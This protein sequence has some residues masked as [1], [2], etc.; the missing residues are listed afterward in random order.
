MIL[1]S[2]TPDTS[3]T[4]QSELPALAQLVNMGYD[5]ITREKARQLRGGNYQNVLLERILKERLQALNRIPS[6]SGG[7]PFSE[8]NIDKAITR[9]RV[10][11]GGSLAQANKAVY[12]K[13]IQGIALEQEVE[14]STQSHSLR[15]IDWQNPDNNRFHVVTQYQVRNSRTNKSQIPDLALFVNGI[16]LA[17]IECKAPH[18]EV[19]DAIAQLRAYQKEE[20]GIPALFHYAQLL[21]AVNRNKARYA[22]VTTPPKFWTHWE[23]PERSKDKEE[24]R[25]RSS[26]TTSKLDDKQRQAIQADYPQEWEELKKEDPST[27]SEQAKLLHSLC[28][29]ERLLEIIRHF[30][31]FDH[32]DKKIARAHQFAVVQSAMRRLRG[33]DDEKKGKLGLIW[34]A[35]GA[36]KSLT[37]VWLT[38]NLLLRR[39]VNNP[40]V[41]LATDRIDLERQLHG[42]FRACQ[43]EPEQA[44]TGKKLAELI[45]AG[46]ARVITTV[47]HK[48]ERV[49][50]QRNLISAEDNIF[51]LVD[52]SH[53]TQYGQ[54]AASMR[55]LLPK[56]HYIGF[57]GTPLLKKEKNTFVTFGESIEPSYPMDKAIKDKVVLPLQYERRQPSIW[58]NREFMDRRF[59]K[60]TKNLNREAQE[61]LKGEYASLSKLIQTDEVI[62]AHA[63]DI[64]RHYREFIKRHGRG[65]KAQLAAPRKKSAIKYLWEL[66]SCEIEAD[67]VISAPN[68]YEGEE[69]EQKQPAPDLVRLFWKEMMDKYG[70]EE[71][72]NET[73]IRRF[74]EGTK[75]TQILI[76]V[77]KLLT[78]F[79]APRNSILYICKS[80]R[81]HSLLQAIARV[82]RV[83][84]PNE[85]ELKDGAIL[86]NKEYGYI[87]DYVNGSEDRDNALA[88][89]ELLRNY[90]QGETEGLME[91]IEIEAKKLRACHARIRQLFKDVDGKNMDAFERRL[92][93]DS[94]RKEFYARLTDYRKTCNL[95]FVSQYWLQNATDEEWRSYRDDLRF[96]TELEQSVRLRYHENSSL[97]VS[98]PEMDDLLNKGIKK[99]PVSEVETVVIDGSVLDSNAGSSYSDNAKQRKADQMLYGLKKEIEDCKEE[100]PEYYASFSERIQQVIDDYRQGKLLLEKYASEADEFQQ[101]FKSGIRRDGMNKEEGSYYD[102]ILEILG[103]ERREEATAISKAF[104]QKLNDSVTNKRSFWQNRNEQNKVRG[105]LDDFLCDNIKD[106]YNIQLSGDNINRIIDT[107][108][109]RA[110]HI[111]QS[112]F[113]NS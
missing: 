106:K 36:G 67:V 109:E 105:W 97:S 50:Q 51:I 110:E 101:E 61:K 88:R 73:I 31:V 83:Y 12:E 11:T 45:A 86:A 43:L 107:C 94:E 84:E 54:I 22:T 17:V 63:A 69:K 41:I 87:I 3:E 18:V 5:Y 52:E 112:P 38:N 59:G 47:V 76:V 21:V 14:G 16:P 27:L 72:Y 85:K 89:D 7:V 24:E 32:D 80:L 91:D 42:T 111:K 13:L 6:S 70:T 2:T 113:I 93:N 90:E 79:D 65:Y 8:E 57:T 102:G 99:G 30:I 68:E 78:G 10:T 75:G 26:L 9:M 92:E 98:R 48:F 37:M 58:Q 1:I 60:I 34:H 66:R 40:R 103:R 104:R 46:S 77:D 4:A 25:A 71:K 28:R 15:Y 20:E 19:E 55:R 108:M 39:E 49:M 56:A 74:K 81:E 64:A 95:A 96:F 44:T 82:N 23:E 62:E 33:A 29:K 53:R 100:S 35:Q